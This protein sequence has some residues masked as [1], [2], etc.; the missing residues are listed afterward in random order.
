MLNVFIIY[1]IILLY[2][3]LIKK[4]IHIRL[5]TDT[6]DYLMLTLS[7]VSIYLIHLQARKYPA[8]KLK[9]IQLRGKASLVRK[10]LYRTVDYGGSDSLVLIVLTRNNVVF[11]LTAH[12]TYK[13][14]KRTILFNLIIKRYRTLLTGLEL[15]EIPT[16]GIITE[17]LFYDTYIYNV[18]TSQSEMMDCIMS[19]SCVCSDDYYFKWV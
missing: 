8:N 10:L 14:I 6:L 12:D 3:N 7:I 2:R 9:W 13:I 17:I 18:P 15:L 16:V 19:M 4:Q 1:Y 11:A 5:S